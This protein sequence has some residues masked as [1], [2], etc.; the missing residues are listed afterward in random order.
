MLRPAHD[1]DSGVVLTCDAVVGCAREKEL[2]G[3]A[4]STARTTI[5]SAPSSH[6]AAS[7]VGVGYQNRLTHMAVRQ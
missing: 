4:R 1:D 2:P 7:L 6:A 5:S 3:T